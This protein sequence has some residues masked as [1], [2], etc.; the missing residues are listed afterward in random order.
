MT[1]F[2]GHIFRAALFALVALL[3][4]WVASAY[5]SSVK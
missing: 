1:R 4:H 5:L 2:L 3:L